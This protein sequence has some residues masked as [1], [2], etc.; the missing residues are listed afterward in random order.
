MP[1]KRLPIRIMGL[2]PSRSNPD[3]L[4]FGVGFFD[5]FLF[6]GFTYNQISGA[7]LPPTQH[8]AGKKIP[9]VKAFP[10]H[11]KRLRGMIEEEIRRL[12][13]ERTD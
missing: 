3:M 11:W 12:N 7:I 5:G 13:A 6:N 10:V 8:Y 9:L 1:T 2:R 4:S